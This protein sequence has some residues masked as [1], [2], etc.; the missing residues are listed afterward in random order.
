MAR[1]AAVAVVLAAGT[2]LCQGS[3][4]LGGNEAPWSSSPPVISGADVE[5]GTLT[6]SSGT[7]HGA[8]IVFTYTWERCGATGSACAPILGGSDQS[9]DPSDSY[10][11]T[12][13]DV[14]S[15]IEVVV[16]ATNPTGSASTTSAPTAAVAAVGEQ[17]AQGSLRS[18]AVWSPAVGRA[19]PVYVYLPPG[20]D[21]SRRPGYPVLYLLH[22]NP[23]GPGSFVGG[24]PAGP[25]ED[26]LLARGRMR[27][28]ILVMPLGGPNTTTETSWANG[29]GA[30]SAWETFLARDV[31]G[32]V[33][34]HFDALP[35]ASDR[36]IAGLSDGGYGAL[37]IALHHPG[38]FGVVESWAGYEYA[39]PAE[40]SVYGDDPRVLAYDSPAEALP[41]EAATLR[42]AGTFFWITVGWKD[43]ERFDNVQFASELAAAHLA[44]TSTVVAGS[45]LPSFY[46]S[47]LPSAFEAA[48]EHFGV[49]ARSTGPSSARGSSILRFDVAQHGA[50]DEPEDGAITTI[51][52]HG[53][54]ALILAHRLGDRETVDSAPVATGTLSVT[55]GTTALTLELDPHAAAVHVA[56]AQTAT[57]VSL[58]V[59]VRA[60]SGAS[61]PVGVDGYVDLEHLVDAA[62]T[63][64][65]LVLD[66]RPR[67]GFRVAFDDAP[68]RRLT[69]T[70][71][72]L[73]F[74]T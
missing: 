15:E 73:R 71:F 56:G 5:G 57:L 20:Y 60:S 9:E 69:G 23:G 50:P 27:P 12:Q 35:N 42:R 61:C 10:A 29:I 28:T 62:G 44:S 72:H 53:R 46:R 22:G 16:T 4:A 45:H 3:T 30:D 41:G 58:P 2:V 37:D 25:T 14:G 39:D 13:A 18:F 17:V 74:R 26:G 64:N 6:A 38:E 43:A 7:W 24:V 1:V 55:V 32:W 36:G 40:T 47:I 31:V 11:L 21:P 19:Q 68:W 33:D 8:D 34:N 49:L 59:T 54:G 63:T 52:V 48:S 65:T 66:F 67:C 51:A 70:T